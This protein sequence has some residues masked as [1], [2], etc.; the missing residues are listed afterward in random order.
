MKF[1]TKAIHIGQEADKST[2]ATIV[3]IYQTSTFTQ[4][5]IGVHKGYD[6]SRSDNPTRTALEECLAS[7]ENGKYALA[8]S[9]GLAATAAVLSVLRPGDNIVA[10]ND[11]YGGT[12]RLF[13]KVYSPLGITVTYADSTNLDELA[14]VVKPETKLIW[15]ETPTN[16]LLKIADIAGI[17]S[18]AEQNNILLA[19]DNTFATPYFQ[20]PLELG[21]DIVV[22]STTKY[23]GGHSD[24]IGGA[25]IINDE[26]IHEKIKFYQNAA[27][28]VPGPF[29][30]WLTLRG[31]KTLAIRMKQHEQ[32]AILIAQALSKHPQVVEV[33]YPGL[34]SHPQYELAKQQMNG[35][36][37]MISFKISGLR[38]EAEGQALSGRNAVNGEQPRGGFEEVNNFMK[39]LKIISL[40]ESLGGVESLVCYPPA[41]THASIPQEERE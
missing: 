3:P 23:I 24:V 7:L 14:A 32:N 21:A 10:S 18:I 33:Y 4:E 22:H 37:G 30:S 1:S 26:E 31:L 39:N 36:G 5:S 11:L 20:Q 27:G 6:Y 34:V 12:Y 35:F 19:V 40:A 16:P 25:V 15:I 2:G 8:F 41:M 13:E 9:S 17:A 28:G 29:D 38:A